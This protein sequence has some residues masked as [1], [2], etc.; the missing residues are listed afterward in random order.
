[1]QHLI[2]VSYTH[3]LFA[4]TIVLGLLLGVVYGVTKPSIDKV[5]ED[6]T[7]NAYKQ[8]FTPL[9]IAFDVMV[10]PEIASISLSADGADLRT[11]SY[12]HLDVYKR[13]LKSSTIEPK[14]FHYSY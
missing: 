3:L 11:V 8:A 14:F 1:M 10:E 6:K 5:N 4:F 13:Q 9:A 7:Q 12:T 2:P